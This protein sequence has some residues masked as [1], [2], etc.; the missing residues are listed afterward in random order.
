MYSR[1]LLIALGLV[2]AIGT[3]IVYWVGGD[4][5]VSGTLEVGTVAAF[6]L[7]VQQ[8]YQP[9]AQ[10]TNSRVDVLTALVSFERVFEVLDFPAAIA[11][12]PGAVDLVDPEGRIEF[13]HVWFRHPPGKLVSLPSL[14]TPGTPGGEEPSE[15]ILRDVSIRVEPGETV[16]LVGP[17][18]AGK[19]TLFDLI[20]RFYDPTGGAVQIDGVD[21]RR[22][23]LAALRSQIGLVPQDSVLFAGTLADNLRYGAAD[24]SLD[25][26]CAALEAAS[27]SAFVE[28]LPE[29][30][31]TRIG[32]DG[33]GLSGGQRQRLAIA[34]ALLKRPRL[35][36]MDEA[37]S[38]LDAQS[39]EAIRRTMRSLKGRCTVLIIA[40]RLSTVVEADRIV[41]LD[42]GRVI[43]EGTHAELLSS[44]P[45][46]RE[47]AE[48]QLGA[49]T[50]ARMRDS[51]SN[52]AASVE[53]NAP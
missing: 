22:C 47:F 17:S 29:G 53:E 12:R 13:D 52:G 42:G 49:D 32:E 46:Y 50:E 15:W 7:Y 23:T 35:L 18:G 39:E 10:L 48:I 34:R 36:L 5:A 26:L 33:A 2:T 27:A 14:E 45:L 9:L 4:L 19:S 30:L 20:L 21:L 8:L 25:E 16:A 44:S 28:A 3:A 43:G 41:V 1:V 6:V 11:D 31:E 38:A 51:G 37:T 24:A 40:H